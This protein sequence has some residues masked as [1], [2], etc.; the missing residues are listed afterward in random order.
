MSKLVLAAPLAG[1]VAPLDEVPDE[2]FAAR[3]MGDGVAIDPLGD[4]LFAPCDGV[5]TTA[6]AHA[7]NLRADGGVEILLH[8]GID[9]V[10]LKGEGFT[11][12]VRQGQQVRTG[13]KLISF[14]LE[15]LAARV[16]SLLSPI[17]ATNGD[18]ITVATPHC[19]RRIGVG[20]PLLEIEIPAATQT[21]N[22][23][24]VNARTCEIV[25]LLP[26]GLHARPAA[27]IVHAVKTF[28]ARVA[29]QVG[30]RRAD[31]ASVAALMALDLGFQDRV[32]LDG[33]G[34]DA[35]AALTA[36]T[37]IIASDGG[38]TKLIADPPAVAPAAAEGGTTVRGIPAAPGL[39]IGCTKR[40]RIA[41]YEVP[42]DGRGIE[43]ENRALTAALEAAKRRLRASA[44]GTAGGADILAAHEAL[45][46]DP[47]LMNHATAEIAAGRSAGYAWRM[48][49]R[50]AADALRAA[51]SARLRARVDDFADLEGQVLAELTDAQPA[52]LAFAA[53]TI[54]LAETLYPSHLAA[55]D[56][57]KIAGIVMAG[58]GPTAHVALLAAAM[59]VPMLAGVGDALTAVPEG[60]EAILDADAGVLDFAPT[61]QR[62]E[63][64]RAAAADA[65][66][67]RTQD[68]AA[69]ARPADTIDGVR[70]AVFANL[71]RG[72]DEAAAAVAAG[73][74]GCGLMRSEFLFLDRSAPP[75]EEEQ[76]VHYQ[77]VADAF[78]GRPVI[79]RTFDI[80][81]DKP[82]P[83]LPQAAEDNPALGMRGIRLA[84]A[85][86]DL[87]R[88]QIRAALHVCPAGRIKLM[89]PMISDL[90]ELTAVKTLLQDLST[91]LSV[92]PPPLGIMI[93]TPAA[94]MLADKFAAAA[95]FF[96]IGT[97]DLTQYT[98][99]MDRTHPGLAG[100][101]DALHPAV[102]R[103]I[104][105]T[106]A[107]A[108]GKSVGVCG[109]LASDP[110]ATAIL[111][112]LGIDE[113]SVP[114]AAVAK[115]K[116]SIRQSKISDCRALAPKALACATA[117]DVRALANATRENKA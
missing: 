72:A 37:D 2:V 32:L 46:D 8:I 100:K 24:T 5:V 4:T 39:A 9:S 104:A 86:P 48:A 30:N 114:A 15:F 92:P 96:S 61:P 103:L 10:A 80:G 59:N 87:L 88:T 6:A 93:E 94:A 115:L 83:Y 91:E 35:E 106:V 25:C 105:Q 112:G 111:I 28:R 7:I 50:T 79:L 29:L 68:V 95:D 19:G 45:L 11:V 47:D 63:T 52:A 36:V 38:E 34:P 44:G 23:T 12:H 57:D 64:V 1:W 116:A 99:A 117:A 16:K 54:L 84:L 3:M 62:L 56:I 71:G 67:V 31:A 113:L 65:A 82:A 102:L 14:N 107:G 49:V 70:I 41:A 109:A 98:L 43:E 89:L 75:S 66:R 73:A 51:G 76:R 74:E 60:I 17:V 97:N 33:N 110:L 20:E 55:L 101:A 78:A 13:D 27:R 69:A 90:A 58:G 22:E 108:A 85:R 53:G 40:W 26:N 77:A 42:T 18:A 81:A 21:A